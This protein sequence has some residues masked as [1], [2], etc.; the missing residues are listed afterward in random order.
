[1]ETWFKFSG[2]TYA[3]SPVAVVRSTA[4]MVVLI[5]AGLGRREYAVHKE[6]TDGSYHPTFAGAKAA[7]VARADREVEFAKDRLAQAIG[8]Q[9]KANTATDPTQTGV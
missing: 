5:G 2:Y 7:M 4:K 8:R 3:V 1:M 9:E 6:S